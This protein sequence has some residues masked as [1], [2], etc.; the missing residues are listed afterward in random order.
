MDISFHFLFHCHKSEWKIFLNLQLF[1]FHFYL[2]RSR[3]KQFRPCLF[4]HCEPIL[5]I[6]GF[7]CSFFVNI[8]FFFILFFFFLSKR[9]LKNWKRY[10]L[11]SLNLEWSR[12]SCFV[13][14]NIDALKYHSSIHIRA[15]NEGFFRLNSELFGSGPDSNWF[16]LRK[17]KISKYLKCF[18]PRKIMINTAE[19]WVKKIAIWIRQFCEA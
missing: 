14:T 9:W 7:L 2:F 17:I 16:D 8:D 13:Q 11:K 3:E 4:F 1:N 12:L 18:S 6:V 5:W 19:I 15:L 10:Q